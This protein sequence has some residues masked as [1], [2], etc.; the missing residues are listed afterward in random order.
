MK[1]ILALIF[2]LFYVF[3][4]TRQEGK[5][6]WNDFH[7]T[8][9]LPAPVLQAVSGYSHN[10]A[11]FFLFVKVSV[12][13]GGTLKGVKDTSYAD[14][15]AQNMDVVTRLYPDFTDPYHYTQS[16]LAP[17]GSDYTAKAN[18]IL[19]RIIAQNKPDLWFFSF[20]KGFN[21]Y[22][23]LE[24][25]K[26]AA[27]VFAGMAERE[28]GPGYLGRLASILMARDGELIA[29]RNMVQ[30]MYNNETDEALKERY[31]VSRDNYDKA[32]L[33]QDA[34]R[35]YEQI[36]GNSPEKLVELVPKY[37]ASLP[38]LE[39]NFKLSWEPPVLKIKRP[40]MPGRD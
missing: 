16:F 28:E 19:D 14:T 12:F 29:G 31:R 26:E 2:L 23:Y 25:N 9:S 20:F 4:W 37:L 35:R 6:Q 30:A 18:E 21:L 10:L 8:P 36:E 40:L 39:E 24:K 3:V 27:E 13:A 5:D 32:L 33:V 15:L 11:G 1:K 34:I 17:I 7:L 38:Q 22:F